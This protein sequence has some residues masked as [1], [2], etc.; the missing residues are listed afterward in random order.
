[1][2][3]FR[4]F[5][6]SV[7]GLEYDRCN[8]LIGSEFGLRWQSA[9]STPLCI[10]RGAR[11]GTTRRLPGRLRLQKKRRRRSVLPAHSKAAAYGEQ[12]RLKAGHPHFSGKSQNLCNVGLNFDSR[13]T[14]DPVAGSSP[15]HG[16]VKEPIPPAGRSCAKPGPRDRGWSSCH[17]R[18]EE[19]PRLRSIPVAGGRSRTPEGTRTLPPPRT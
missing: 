5:P 1:M 11:R 8:M 7:G 4:F 14:P 6:E 10:A 15:A 3:A 13:V 16:L 18:G 19:R 9:A 17:R 12:E 2:C